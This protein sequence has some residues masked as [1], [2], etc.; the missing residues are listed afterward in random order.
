VNSS[1]NVLAQSIDS[2]EDTPIV[3]HRLI[4]EEPEASLKCNILVLKFS[5]TYWFLAFKMLVDRLMQTYCIGCF[6]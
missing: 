4:N 2:R 6:I 1:V 5:T 3:I